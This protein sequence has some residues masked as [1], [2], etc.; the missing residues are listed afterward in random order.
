MWAQNRPTALWH[1]AEGLRGKACELWTGRGQDLELAL[2]HNDIDS[3]RARIPGCTATCVWCASVLFDVPKRHVPQNVHR[4]HHGMR[5]ARQRPENA[6]PRPHS[7]P[8]TRARTVPALPGRWW[9]AQGGRPELPPAQVDPPGTPPAPDAAR[10][11]PHCLAHLP[12][13]A[14]RRAFRAAQPSCRRS[15]ASWTD[16]FMAARQHWRSRRLTALRFAWYWKDHP[17]SSR[18]ETP[19]E[20]PKR[21]G[22]T[23][24]N[25]PG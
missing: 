5:A 20:P 25:P 23:H 4:C 24:Q 21:C 6:R 1:P 13:R 12:S 8:G 22:L 3:H 11:R 10:A 9:G 18:L 16:V 19:H 7:T 14:R 17:L 15:S 2:V